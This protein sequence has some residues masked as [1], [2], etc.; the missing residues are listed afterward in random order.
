MTT[1]NG[2]NIISPLTLTTPHIENRFVRD[3]QTI[4]MFVPLTSTVVLKCKKNENVVCASR[5]QERP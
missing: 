4:N 3:E 2:D 5:V 1:L